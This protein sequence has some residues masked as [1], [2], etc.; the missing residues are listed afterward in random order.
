MTWSAARLQLRLVLVV[1]LHLDLHDGHVHDSFGHVLVPSRLRP[2]AAIDHLQ[3][4]LDACQLLLQGIS[5]LTLIDRVI[6]LVLVE[7]LR[8]HQVDD[9]IFELALLL[10]QRKPLQ[11]LLVG[12]ILAT[13]RLRRRLCIHAR[14]PHL[15]WGCG[16]H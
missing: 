1:E 7:R 8:T 15:L 12:D 16:G 10:G 2:N 4:L 14:V 3:V 11:L 6:R 13:A 5:R 9:Q